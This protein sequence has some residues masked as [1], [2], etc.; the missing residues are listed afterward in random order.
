MPAAAGTHGH[1]A[2]V[3]RALRA[4]AHADFARPLG[5][6]HHDGLHVAGGEREVDETLGI[7]ARAAGVVED[8]IVQM[9]HGEP[10]RVLELHAGEERARELQLA[11]RAGVEHLAGDRCRVD[12][13]LGRASAHLE[14]ARRDVRVAERTRIREDREVDVDGDLAAQRDAEG[15]HEFEHQLP[16]GRRRLIEPVDRAVARVAEVVIDVDDDVPVESCDAGPGEIAALQHERRVELAVH[17][18][19]D[20]DVR[21]AGK[22]EV[23]RRHRIVVDE[24]HVLA[25]AA[26]RPGEGELRANRVAVGTRV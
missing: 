8:L 10:A 6:E 15:I 3:D 18:V 23:R 26:Q 7:V 9:E 24:A 19:G 25:Q 11:D 21:R 13:G 17:G 12:A 1:R 2:H 5:P 16:A 14:G 22:R 20:L 4:Q